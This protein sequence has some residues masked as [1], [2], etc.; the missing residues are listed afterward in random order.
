MEAV[1]KNLPYL[2]PVF[3][4]YY[5][6][7]DITSGSFCLL[8]ICFFPI[9]SNWPTYCIFLLQNM[10][11][12]NAQ[13][14]GVCAAYCHSHLRYSWV[15]FIL[16]VVFFYLAPFPSKL[17]FPRRWIFFALAGEWKAVMDDPARKLQ[18]MRFQWD[19]FQKQLFQFHPS[20]FF[21]Y[22]QWR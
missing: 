16:G 17:L 13:F 4:A 3:C 7:S 14:F 1:V 9:Q 8:R 22:Q 21:T 15:F 18:N 11:N 6:F 5:I 2:F 20:S 12:T 10:A 19:V